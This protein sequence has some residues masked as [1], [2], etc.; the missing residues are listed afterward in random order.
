MTKQSSILV[1]EEV[2][3]MMNVVEV[4]RMSEALKAMGLTDSQ[5]NV[6]INYIA[7]GIGLP[8]STEQSK[9]KESE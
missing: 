8:E 3:E 6:V 1:E 9:E 7:T 5:I 4:A 2:E